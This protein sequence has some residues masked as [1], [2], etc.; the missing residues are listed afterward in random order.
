[1]D[2]VTNLIEESFDSSFKWTVNNLFAANPKKNYI[3]RSKEKNFYEANA[4]WQIK[5]S[6]FVYNSGERFLNPTFY[7]RDD[8]SDENA[9]YKF[10]ITLDDGKVFESQFIA[11]NK[12]S[13]SALL[14]YQMSQYI[15]LEKDCES[16][17]INPK[18]VF[19]TLSHNTELEPEQELEPEPE[20][21]LEVTVT[22]GESE[23]DVLLDS[24]SLV[25]TESEPDFRIEAAMLPRS[26]EKEAKAANVP[27]FPK[28]NELPVR[29]VEDDLPPG[30]YES[31]AKFNK[32]F[33]E[34]AKLQSRSA[35]VGT[36]LA[37]AVATSSSA[38]TSSSDCKDSDESSSDD[39]FDMSQ[40]ADRMRPGYK[41]SNIELTRRIK[42]I[43]LVKMKQIA[44]TSSRLLVTAAR[45]S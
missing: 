35:D 30:S 41:M 34:A 19:E 12:T 31:E 11:K 21:E 16:I 45:V 9:R 33:E 4:T 10:S 23:Y 17:V 36:L 13:K 25:K 43:Y 8:G 24:M 40:E 32:A 37:S 2:I 29:S 20:A 6:S 18:V 14:E 28:E 26:H 42:K 22:D 27:E 44:E 38:M 39:C 7:L 3:I 5:L 15:P 1:M